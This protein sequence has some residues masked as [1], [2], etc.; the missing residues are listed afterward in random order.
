MNAYEQKQEEKRQRLEARAAAAERESKAAYSKASQMA[1][2]IPFGQPILVGHHSEGR[3][4]RFRGRIHDT[5]GKAFA[6]MDKAE[7]YRGKAESVGGGGI[8]S[9]DP[10]AITKLR[11][12]LQQLT[13]AHHLMKAAN[14][15]IREQR[16]ADEQVAALVALGFGDAMAREAIKPDFMG[17]TGFPSY[18][19]SNSSANMRRITA[20]IEDLEKRA[21]LETV[22]IAEDGFTYAEDTDENRVM[23]TFPGKPD[24]ETRTLLKRN[25]FKWSP[26]RGAWVR[27]L[28]NAGRYAGQVV[29]NTLAKKTG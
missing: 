16:G 1:S 4:R 26:T 29:R 15:A 3:D 11:A 25:G 27:Q 6:A 2:A 5:Y 12:E 28:N 10:D 14:K 9:D 7:H 21:K 23:F 8:S 22:E 18:A 20:R 13:N 19:L 24:E 17:R